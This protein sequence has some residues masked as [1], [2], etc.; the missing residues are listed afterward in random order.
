MF[1]QNRTE[2]FH[3]KILGVNFTL[4][5]AWPHGNVGPLYLERLICV[6]YLEIDF[7]DFIYLELTLF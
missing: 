1:Y 7:I 4:L 5:A 2:M 3:A 6:S